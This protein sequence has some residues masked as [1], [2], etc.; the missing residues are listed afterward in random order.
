MTTV[1][2]GSSAVAWWVA[3]EKFK[4]TQHADDDPNVIPLIQDP[5]RTAEMFGFAPAPLYFLNVKGYF[6]YTVQML[7]LI[8]AAAL[9]AGRPEVKKALLAPVR[10]KLTSVLFQVLGL[11]STAFA[12]VSLAVT[13]DALASWAHWRVYSYLVTQVSGAI[14]LAVGLGNNV[15]TFMFIVDNKDAPY[16][17]RTVAGGLVVLGLVVGTPI[18]AALMTAGL[19]GMLAYL[20]PSLILLF[21][22]YL[23]N[24]IRI[25]GCQ[26]A[27]MGLKDLCV[28]VF[29]QNLKHPTGIFY[30]SMTWLI[31]LTLIWLCAGITKIGTWHLVG[32]TLLELVLPLV[33]VGALAVWSSPDQK[34]DD[35]SAVLVLGIGF[36][37]AMI[38]TYFIAMVMPASLLAMDPSIGYGGAAPSAFMAKKGVTFSKYTFVIPVQEF[39]KTVKAQENNTYV[40]HMQMVVAQAFS[41]WT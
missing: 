24:A 20:L 29:G 5:D 36:V 23:L 2:S 30:N 13:S 41:F 1:V 19:Y 8:G 38:S 39:S 15:M 12:F 26:R 35:N 37:V 32:A 6:N 10:F 22:L 25:V 3:S 33:G 7:L 31:M 34:P 40:P 11:S 18:W 14:T 27:C 28:K 16:S 17:E 9:L 21:L 4:H